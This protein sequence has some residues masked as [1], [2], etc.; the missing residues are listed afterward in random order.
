MFARSKNK[1]AVNLKAINMEPQPPIRETERD[2][3]NFF[4]EIPDID[5]RNIKVSTIRQQQVQQPLV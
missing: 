3:W 5:R 4:M 2:N 1:S